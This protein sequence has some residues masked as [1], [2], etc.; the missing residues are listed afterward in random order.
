[1]VDKFRKLLGLS[2]TRPVFIIGTGR[3]GTHWLANTF[4][5]HSDID[6]TV[7][8][9]PMFGL[10]QQIALN[11]SLQARLLPELITTY[12]QLVSKSSRDLYMDKSHTNIWI[13]ED[14]KIAFPQALFIG[15]VR[16]PYATVSSMMRHKGVLQWH[17]RW[18]EF[19]VPNQFLGITTENVDTYDRMSLASKC[20]M[21]WSAHKGK[22][23]NLK[24]ALGPD[25]LIIS[26]ESF[27]DKTRETTE[28]LK[29]FL[30]LRRA[31]PI[32]HVKRGSMQSWKEL[33][34][35]Q[36]LQDIRKLVHFSPE[37]LCDHC[38][39]SVLNCEC[40]K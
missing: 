26:Y 10:S 2:V 31:P 6:L 11:P 30:G 40:D 25:L 19:P 34:S 1:M 39:A 38:S 4:V 18:R 22:M 15:I 37:G 23:N 8:Q 14:L 28:Y 16:G 35:D 21:R 3:S 33:L 13:A 36:D 32:P 7:E 17:E 9:Q 24:A 12:E 5:D 20:A 27:Q 29:T